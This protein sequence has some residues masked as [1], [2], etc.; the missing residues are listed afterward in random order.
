M[1]FIGEM[2]SMADDATT[3]KLSTADIAPLSMVSSAPLSAASTFRRGSSSRA[4]VTRVRLRSAA[5][6]RED[7]AR[8][9]AA[10]AAGS[11]E[12]T[13]RRRMERWTGF[14]QLAAR[15]RQ[16][17]RSA[18][19]LLAATQR[20]IRTRGYFCLRLW[21]VI[22]RGKKA[23]HHDHR[24]QPQ[25][26]VPPPSVP[27]HTLI[28][29]HTMPQPAAVRHSPPPVVR[30]T[31][32]QLLAFPESRSPSRGFILSPAEGDGVA[33]SSLPPRGGSPAVLYRGRSATPP[34]VPHPR[35]QSPEPGGAPASRLRDRS[36]E[37]HPDPVAAQPAP[38]LRDRS[39]ERLQD[40]V[41]P[42]AAPRVQNPSPLRPR[43]NDIEPLPSA[44]P[45]S[46]ELVQL[47]VAELLQVAALR[48]KADTRDRHFPI[49]EPPPERPVTSP[50]RGPRLP[51]SP[52]HRSISPGIPRP[53]A[54]PPRSRHPPWPQHPP[55][56]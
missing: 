33:H 5:R 34:R 30:P 29:P 13:L 53:A 7:R 20:T 12:R 1:A 21:A 56:G 18:G 8:V 50:L 42:P 26:S 35:L 31:F 32:A 39:P 38:I 11:I 36:P 24:Q 22:S 17:K 14:L 54:T 55:L 46:E 9:V 40:T 43:P 2:V 47:R 25:N 37:R 10:V 3:A 16:Q 6:T 23:R 28:A 41:A 19:V 4:L 27:S 49:P 44:Y 45:P 48:A 51:R 15:R 52:D